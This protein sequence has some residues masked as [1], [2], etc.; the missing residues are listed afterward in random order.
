MCSG[1]STGV[2]VMAEE[3]VLL[4]FAQLV[5]PE[6]RRVRRAL[7]GRFGLDIGVEV[8]AEVTVWAWEHQEKVV[9]ASN[10]GGLLWRVGQSKARPYLRWVRRRSRV[11]LVP[12]SVVDEYRP[13]LLDLVRNL[14]ALRNEER[15]AVVLVH[16]HGET[17]ADVADLLGIS[18]RA[19]G[20]HVHRGV[21]HLR[22]LMEVAE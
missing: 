10:R 5:E 21:A 3:I 7:V 16:A 14:G 8:A 19:V 11:E 13:E 12:E 6:L 22:R 15:I 9:A 20:N 18:V 1:L 17:Y 2:D 4:D